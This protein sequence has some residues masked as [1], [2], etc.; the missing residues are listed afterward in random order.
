MAEIPEPDGNDETIGGSE[1]GV[2]GNYMDYRLS[3]QSTKYFNRLQSHTN[4]AM[5]DNH[6]QFGKN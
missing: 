4:Y 6:G 1:S 2:G 5:D 3:N